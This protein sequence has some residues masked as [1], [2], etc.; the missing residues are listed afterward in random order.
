M[1]P[2][3]HERDVHFLGLAI[4]E[5]QK[6]FLLGEVPV[7]AVL[8]QNET[9][10]AKAHNL[11][12][13]QKSFEAHAEFLALQA[14]QKKIGDWRLNGLT[15]YTTL[16]PCVLCAGAI[17]HSRISRVVYA[18]PDLKWGACGSV[19][20]ILNTKKFN[21]HVTLLFLPVPEAKTLLTSFFKD[22]RKSLR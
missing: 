3:Q 14:G 5:A 8:V 19:V 7:G 2:S 16:E 12:E 21:H 11:K 10:L 18:A 6:A 17:L 9:I 15:L 13:T 4:E 1:N 22:K 20:D